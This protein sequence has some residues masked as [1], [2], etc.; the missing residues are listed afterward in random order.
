MYIRHALTP[1][2]NARVLFVDMNG[3]FASIEQQDRPELRGKPVAVVSHRHP[4]GTVLA[5]SYEAKALGI[6]TGTRVQEATGR[7]PGIALLEVRADRYRQV[8]ISFM[9]VLRNLCGPEVQPK[10]IDEAAIY[11]SP[12]WQDSAFAWRLALRIKEAF[13]EHVGECIRCSIGIAPNTLLAK[14]GTNLRKPDGLFEITLETA[15]TILAGLDLVDLPGIAGKMSRRLEAANIVTPT[16][17]YDADPA[18][19]RAQFGIWGQYWW[20]RLH[21]FEC[22]VDRD[23]LKSMSHE[24]VLPRWIQ[25]RA[26]IETL[27]GKMADRLLNRLTRNELRCRH[28]WL[29]L[30]FA[31]GPHFHQERTLDTPSND[32]PSLMR[33][34]QDLLK[35]LPKRLG[36]P[37][38]KEVLGL[39]GLSPAAYGSQ[40]NLFSESPLRGA[41]LGKAMQEVRNR[42]GRDAIQVGSSLAAAQTM[43]LK[44]TVGFGRV[45]DR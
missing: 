32:T 31:G 42:Y 24:H 41:A 26:E 10:S 29:D 18:F 17:L 40:L 12:N 43:S 39:G 2:R 3:F 11:L 8:H 35:T 23:D 38:R 14:L 21:G 5:S 6:T 4:H 1:P 45:K 22:N 9:E 25:T 34:F 20:W 19:L 36:L 44:D 15:R 16:D 7:C 27:T 33:A 13:R 28:L 30:K 37:V